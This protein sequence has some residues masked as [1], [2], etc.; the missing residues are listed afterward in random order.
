MRYSEALSVVCDVKAVTV[1]PQERAAARQEILETLAQWSPQVEACPFD[2]DSFWVGSSGLSTL[3]GTE[4]QWGTSV[5][6]ALAGRRYRG[7]VVIG[8]TR[9]GTYVVART[10]KRSAVVHTLEA[11]QRALREA[12]LSLFPLTVRNRR[13]LDR[14]GI[15]TLSALEA[16]PADEVSRRFGPELIRELRQLEAW[17]QLPLQPPEG[18][19]EIVRAR[20]LEA[21]VSDRQALLPLLEEP[22]HS[23]LERLVQ[24]G[25]LL[26]ELQLVFVLESHG[27]VCERLRPAEPTTDQKTL[28]RLLELR[29]ARLGFPTGVIEFRLTFHHVGLPAGSG[30]LFAPPIHRDGR[31]GAEAIAVIQAQWGNDAVVRPV[32]VDSHVPELSFR[33][34]PVETLVVPAPERPSTPLCTAVRRIDFAGGETRA[35]PA[36]E[37]LG[38]ALRLKVTSGLSRVDKDYWFLRNGRQEVA[39]VSWDRLTSAAR[40]EG[41]VD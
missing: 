20:R 29:L 34:E 14:L 6:E 7:V 16:L 22:L 41:M 26:A 19:E 15:T 24:R 1:S 25:R 11:E 27:L 36:G 4:A 37:R 28:L 39:W 2:S 18:P 17:T 8:L 31:K 40:W 32:L 30:E 10:R 38:R 35:N 3:Y 9:G 33:W 12:P 21:P 23:G 5:R 13:L